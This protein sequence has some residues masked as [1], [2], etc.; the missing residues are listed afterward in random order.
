MLLHLLCA[1]YNIC[2]IFF[3]I[4]VLRVYF[5]A[6][7]LCMVFLSEIKVFIFSDS[8]ICWLLTTAIA[9]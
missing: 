3:N 2:L 6:Y 8:L 7:F 5:Y 4:Y 9:S 1:S